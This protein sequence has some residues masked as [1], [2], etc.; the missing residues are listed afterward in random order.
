M[1]R[2]LNEAFWARPSLAGLGRIPWNALFFGGAVVLGFGMPAIW[3]A[4]AGAE[5]LYL[6]AVATN[7]RFQNWVD[8]KDLERLHAGDDDSSRRLVANL[9]EPQRRRQANIEDK[10]KRIEKVYRD[11]QNEDYLYESNRDA[12]QKLTTMFA[13][14]LVAQRNMQVL[15]VT[16][17]ESDLRGQIASIEKD[18]TAPS[19]SDALRESKKATQT[20][21]QQRLRNLQ[22]RGESLAEIDSDLTRIEQQ[23]DLAVEDASL[24]GRPTAISA[25]IDLVSHLLDDSYDP[26]TMAA[27]LPTDVTS[28]DTT[29][30]APASKEL[31]N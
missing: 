7:G 8:A 9:P 16:S 17:R 28:S 13:R 3:L 22:R 1:L 30:S 27:N 10:C 5:T 4:A 24:K 11:S 14:L 15:D 23:I 2:Y 21:L 20:I 25:N 12:L 18:L 29:T 26:A 31:E 6:Y 19:M